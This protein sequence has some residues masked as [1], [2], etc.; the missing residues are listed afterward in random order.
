MASGF[1]GQ[2]TCAVS[3][4]QGTSLA[5]PAVAGA[6]VLLRDALGRE[7]HAR[8]SPNGYEMSSYN[9]SNPSSAL[10]KALLI[11]STRPLPFGY[12]RKDLLKDNSLCFVS[13]L[14]ILALI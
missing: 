8:L 13:P 9:A 1:A 7:L 5:A 4:L 2:A 6:A 14:I 12:C 3:T 10:L 11:G